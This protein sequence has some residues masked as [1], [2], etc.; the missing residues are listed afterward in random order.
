MA[1]TVRSLGSGSSGNALLVES[2]TTAVLVDCG[3]GARGLAAGLASAGRSLRA[4]D[5]V[6][7]SHEHSDHVRSLPNVVRAAVPILT[8]NGT[9]RAAHV[10]SPLWHEVRAG[11][12]V[13]VG[14]L[15][16][17]PTGVSHDAAEPCGFHLRAAD[18]AVTIV[19]DIG[20]PNDAIADFVA[21]SDLIVLE[22]N[23]DEQMLRFGPYPSYL[24]R[25]VLSD[26]GHL[27]NA[28]CAALLARALRTGGR[29]RSI[30]LAHLSQ[31]NNRPRLAEQAV[32]QHLVQT[33]TAHAV[34]ALPRHGHALVWRA[35]D[36]SPIA[37]QAALPLG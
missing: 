13:R 4:L 17:T 30:W 36:T 25:R 12:P 11:F 21:D 28:D 22:A 15:T 32:A 33:G 7:I 24:K 6:L 29:S 14:D 2:A 5:A 20:R 34:A 1:L 8:T 23:H 27:S 18:A 10:P 9:A 3:V 31:T 26:V 35:D 16:I 19:T 37:V